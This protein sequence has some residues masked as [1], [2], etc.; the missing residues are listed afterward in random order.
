MVTRS[1][2]GIRSGRPHGPTVRVSPYAAR[3]SAGEGA[4]ILGGS[5]VAMLPGVVSAGILGHYGEMGSEVSDY[6]QGAIGCLN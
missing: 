3:V 2:I 1:A 6:A 4:G 5:A